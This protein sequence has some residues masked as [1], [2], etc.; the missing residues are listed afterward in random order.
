[1]PGDSGP[2]P[3]SPAVIVFRSEA[4]LMVTL[5]LNGEMFAIDM[6]DLL[7]DA[8]RL[9]LALSLEIEDAYQRGY[10]RAKNDAAQL[11]DEALPIH[12]HGD[13][14]DRIRNLKSG[15]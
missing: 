1:M 4:G 15:D 3:E 12:R 8:P 9:H 10:E 7:V 6:Y 5:K 13:V 11:V 2:F 14:R